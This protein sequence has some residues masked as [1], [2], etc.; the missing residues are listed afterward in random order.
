MSDER[1]SPTPTHPNCP[2]CASGFTG[3]PGA[4]CPACG[5]TFTPPAMS[6]VPD[7]RWDRSGGGS[8]PW[9]PIAYAMAIVGLPLLLIVVVLP[10]FGG[11]F[12]AFVALLTSP[13]LYIVAAILLFPVIIR[14]IR[15]A[16]RPEASGAGAGHLFRALFA[17]FGAAALAGLA[18]AIAFGIVCFAVAV[19][20]GN[21]TNVDAGFIVGGAAGLAVFVLIF[22]LLWPR[23]KPGPLPPPRDPEN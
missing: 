11:G 13:G 5:R 17:S 2:V 3:T 23:Q 14:T 9:I 1:I 15:I 22:V 21:F 12:D 20:D 4:S 6:A 18:S 10:I 19:G 7:V 8:S 16:T